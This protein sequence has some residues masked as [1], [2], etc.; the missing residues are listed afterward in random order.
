MASELLV[1]SSFLS[2]LETHCQHLTQ[3][4]TWI[5]PALSFLPLLVSGDL[6]CSI[7]LTR[8]SSLSTNY[9]CTMPL[10]SLV[11]ILNQPWK[12]QKSQ[13]S[14]PKPQLKEY[15][16]TGNQLNCIASRIFQILTSPAALL[17][18]CLISKSWSEGL[19][20]VRLPIPYWHWVGR[21]RRVP[22]AE[23]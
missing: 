8:N 11:S 23:Q 7:C 3:E 14:C 9:C 1:F 16:A 15:S 22:I 10:G 21:L 17:V 12:G 2:P 4:A 18:A 19:M 13:A 20:M 5:G 6:S